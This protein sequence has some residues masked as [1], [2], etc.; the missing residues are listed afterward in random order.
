MKDELPVGAIAHNPIAAAPGGML[1]YLPVGLF[2]SVMGLAG[3]SVAWRLAHEHFGVWASVSQW[4]GAVAMVVFALVGG[5]YFIK[6]VTAPQAVRAEFV[7]PIAGNLFATILISLVLVPIVLAPISLLFARIMWAAGAIGMTLFAWFVLSRW[8]RVRQQV[9]HATPAW[10]VPVVGM[11]NVPLAMP[12]LEL[13]AWHG[14][15]VLSLAIGLFF[16]LPLFTLIFSRLVF[17][18]PLPDELQPSLLILLA[19]FAVG[20]STCIVA[21]GHVDLFS[22]SLFA[23]TLFMLTV[24]LGRLR[25]LGACCPFRVSWWSVSFPLAAC[26]IAGLRIAAAVRSTA[27][28]LIAIV[29]LGLASLVVALLLLRTLFGVVRGE[30]RTLSG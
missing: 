11:L 18:S 27:T 16:T 22:N 21:T 26:A 15:M 20:T 24:L 10:L 25:H 3:L 28:D 17:E 13:T 19:P 30:L 14:V 12:S 7:N 29:L 1:E 4:T 8:M 5:G 2:G 9:T 23:L 6:T